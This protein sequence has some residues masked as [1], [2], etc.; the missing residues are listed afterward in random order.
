MLAVSE[1]SG[2]VGR[3]MG[4]ELLQRVKDAS[5][6][7]GRKSGT[8]SDLEISGNSR[9][10]QKSARILLSYCPMTTSNTGGKDRQIQIDNSLRGG[11]REVGYKTVKARI[12]NN[13]VT[14]VL[15]RTHPKVGVVIQSRREPGPIPGFCGS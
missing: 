8:N 1:R 7:C 4:K 12:D 5:K 3:G 10:Q 9:K 6:S 11:K 13:Y 2:E 15:R 14:K